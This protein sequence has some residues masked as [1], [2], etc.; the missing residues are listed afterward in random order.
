MGPSAAVPSVEASE[1]ASLLSSEASL[2]ASEEASLEAE[3]VEAEALLSEEL[4]S[5]FAAGGQHGDAQRGGHQNGNCFFHNV[6]LLFSF[7]RFW[8]S[9]AG[10]SVRQLCKM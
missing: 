4:L 9:L 1:E 7:Q 10:P 8:F 5:V 2:E 6:D 3:E